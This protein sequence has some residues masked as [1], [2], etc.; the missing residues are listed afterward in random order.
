M[1]MVCCIILYTERERER[2]RVCVCVCVCVR[3]REREREREMY[4]YIHS[5]SA[6]YSRK[7]VRRDRVKR[8]GKHYWMTSSI[9]TQHTRTHLYTCPT[10]IH[11]IPGNYSK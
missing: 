4:M 6:L 11:I 8:N 3:E 2:E 10:I 5:I 7:R 9:R 1:D